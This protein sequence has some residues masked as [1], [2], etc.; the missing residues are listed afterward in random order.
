ML[1]ILSLIVLICMSDML[2]AQYTYTIKADS[3]KIT[4]C[5]SSELIIENHTQGVSGF[6]FNTGRGRTIF[7]KGVVKINGGL[8]LIGAD[9]L[10][11]N[12]N[13]WMQG[14]NSFGATGVLGTLDNNHLDLYTNDTGRVRLTNTGQLFVGA[15]A[16]FWNPGGLVDKLYVN[17]NATIQGTFVV[18]YTQTAQMGNAI[19]FDLYGTGATAMS[20]IFSQKELFYQS[21]ASGNQHLF[22]NQI[23]SQFT[24][25]L[26]TMDPGPYPQLPSSQLTLNVLNTSGQSGLA[27]NVWGMVGMGTSS[28]S[29]QLHTTGTVR[30]A[31]LTSDS[32][33]TRV[34]VS[35]ANGNLYYRSASS[36]ASNGML[37]SSLAEQPAINSSLT[38]NGEIRAEGLR[39]RPTQW[40]DYV[41]ADGYRLASLSEVGRYI[42]QNNHLPGMPPAAEVEKKGIDVGDNQAAL[43]KKIEELTLYAIAQ[44]KSTDEQHKKLEEI[45]EQNRKLAQRVEQLEKA[46]KEFESLKQELSDLKKMIVK[47]PDR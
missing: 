42:K 17:G 26:V 28:P 6:L 44:E 25:N 1:R 32:T 47:K 19:V 40:A 22:Q 3:V 9:T 27:V 13:A 38:V 5:D 2:F 30:F 16:D 45:E 43:L 31:G 10:N 15:K 29:A 8:Y 12:A 7:K 18:T 36:L 33:Q 35:D 11:L 39:L 24:G 14:G 41:F 34:I 46:N 4:N 37:N 23:G 21:G 20:Q